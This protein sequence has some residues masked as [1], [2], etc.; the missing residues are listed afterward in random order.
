MSCA[1]L[2]FTGDLFRAAQLFTIDTDRDVAGGHL[3]GREVSSAQ[4]KATF[5]I[6]L[7]GGVKKRYLVGHFQLALARVSQTIV[8]VSPV[9]LAQ[10]H[11]ALKNTLEGFMRI[12]GDPRL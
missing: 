3:P 5:G 12:L 11:V 6:E 10:I 9:I 7:T 8:V 1:A 2:V 4:D